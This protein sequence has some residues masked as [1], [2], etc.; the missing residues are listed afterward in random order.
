M[1]SAAGHIRILLVIVFAAWIAG[2]PERLLAQSNGEALLAAAES[3]NLDE[4]R[5]LASA[6]APLD[7]RDRQGRTALLIAAAKSPVRS[8]TPAPCAITGKRYSAQIATAAEAVH[9]AEEV[10]AIAVRDAGLEAGGQPAH[11][12]GAAVIRP[13]ASRVAR[14]SKDTWRIISGNLGSGLDRGLVRPTEPKL[15]RTQESRQW[16]GRARAW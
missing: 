15:F 4:V 6:G 14:A 2:A 8:A 5:R 9:F 11:P 1:R 13:A 10:V 7:A 3:N 16:R 12:A